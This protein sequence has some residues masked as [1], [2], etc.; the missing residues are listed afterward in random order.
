MRRLLLSAIAAG[1]LM[2]VQGASA[3][4]IPAPVYKAPPA[5]IWSWSGFYFGGNVGG[6]WIRQDALWTASGLSFNHDHN[7][8]V[9]GVQGGVQGQWNNFVLGVEAAWWTRWGGSGNQQTG[10]PATGCPSAAFTCQTSLRDVWTIGP[11][12]G[13]AA[14]NWLVYV[15]GGYANGQIQTRS[16][17]NATGVVFD[18]FSNRHGGWFAGVGAEWALWTTNPTWAG[19][20]GIEYQHVDLGTTRMCSPADAVCPG[21]DNRDVKTTADV[22]RG[23][24]SIKI[25]P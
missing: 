24:F 14:N 23:R 8:G 9:W 20:L 10:T 3:A 1:T 2:M 12:A 22:I 21:V 11:R 7:R 13:I 6:E 19:I 15:T 5:P 17:A 16:F 18:D 25:K 4:D